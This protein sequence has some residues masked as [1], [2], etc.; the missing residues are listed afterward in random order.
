MERLQ[1]SLKPC[2]EPKRFEEAV[3]HVLEWLWGVGTLLDLEGKSEEAK[4]V[5][6]ML[7]EIERKFVIVG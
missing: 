7:D 4:A 3:T 5:V 2:R 6:T 1:A